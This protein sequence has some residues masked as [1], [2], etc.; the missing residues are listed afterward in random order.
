[1]CITLC[2]QMA[3]LPVLSGHHGEVCQCHRGSVITVMVL[4]T[5]SH[6]CHHHGGSIADSIAASQDWGGDEW[7]GSK[8]LG[9]GGARVIV[10]ELIQLSER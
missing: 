4:L 8:G 5:P 6:H 2:H 3:V 1:M 10:L 9:G 7:L